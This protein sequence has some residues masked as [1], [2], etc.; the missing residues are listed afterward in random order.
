MFNPIV[1]SGMLYRW[2]I[3][4]IDFI[5]IPLSAYLC[6]QQK[7]LAVERFGD[8]GFGNDMGVYVGKTY[9]VMQGTSSGSVH[10]Q[11]SSDTD[12]RILVPYTRCPG[13]QTGF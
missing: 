7:I 13:L 8:F 1:V 5:G 9:W 6:H 4:M 12:L 10:R 2:N 11:V 3:L